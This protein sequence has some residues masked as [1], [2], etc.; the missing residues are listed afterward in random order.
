MSEIKFVA[1][2]NLRLA[3]VAAL[4]ASRDAQFV[5]SKRAEYRELA[6]EFLKGGNKGFSDLAS[7]RRRPGMELIVS[8][9]EKAVEAE[10][11]RI[12]DERC[13]EIC[14]DA[15]TTILNVAAGLQALTDAALV[16]LFAAARDLRVKSTQTTITLES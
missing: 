12:G 14:A 10:A 3:M 6:K 8:A 13:S 7:Y 4:T 9:A 1:V 16:E 2:E 15:M 5:D 11:I